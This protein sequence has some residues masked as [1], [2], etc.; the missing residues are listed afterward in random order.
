[1]VLDSLSQFHLGRRILGND[2]CN[3]WPEVAD[4]PPGDAFQEVFFAS[5]VVVETPLLESAAVCGLLHRGTMVASLR[6]HPCRLPENM[7]PFLMSLYHFRIYLPTVWQAS[8]SLM[9]IYWLVNYV[10]T[11][12]RLCG[13]E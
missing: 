1:M 13:I 8:V 4:R 2:S 5:E 3:A 11:P 9:R 7:F 10:R 6:Y 12:F